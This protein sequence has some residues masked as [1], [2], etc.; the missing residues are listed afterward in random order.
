MRTE[1]HHQV[2]VDLNEIE[3]ALLQTVF[4]GTEPGAAIKLLLRK[5]GEGDPV[6]GEMRQ[7]GLLLQQVVDRLDGI[8]QQISDLI[9]NRFEQLADALA[10]AAIDERA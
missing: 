4:P 1:I 2:N 3:I 7:I 6:A 9:S 10:P 8:P 5:F